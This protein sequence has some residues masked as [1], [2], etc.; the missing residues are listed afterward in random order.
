[1]NSRFVLQMLG[2]AAGVVM[3]ATSVLGAEITPY[4]RTPAQGQPKSD[5]GIN[6]GANAL[7]LSG[8]ITA[9]RVGAA[10]LVMPQL[11]SSFAIAPALK[12]ET[13]ATFANWNARTASATDAIETKLTAHSVLPML[14]E[15]EGMVGRNV[16]GES[17]H[18]LRFKMNDA[19]IASIL[20]KPILLKTNA[21]IE[22][23]DYGRVSGALLTGVEAALVQN[24]A[25]N[26][27]FNRI[28]YKYTTKTGVTEY[29]RQAAAFS[30]SWAQNDVLRLGVEYE[31]MQE[32][33]DQHST[34]RFTWKAYF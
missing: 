11:V 7:N 21:S 1:M 16:A 19:A 4:L 18:K 22:Q 20:S 3:L 8:A 10:T 31:L 12:L 33:A 15:I 32:A 30:R 23:I 26:T 14:A 27:A 24:S 17:R 2:T 25:S 9:K 34:F 13:R 28:G 6:V 5:I 29:Q